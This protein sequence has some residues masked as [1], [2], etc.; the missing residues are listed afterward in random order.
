MNKLECVGDN[1]MFALPD[2]ATT[3]EGGI[4]KPEEVIVAEAAKQEDLEIV[5]VISIGKN[6]KSVKVGDK[7]FLSS[8]R[9]AIYTFENKRYGGIKEYDIFAKVI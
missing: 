7:I 4:I 8:S 1:I 6:V 3:T 9:V 2:V 5:E